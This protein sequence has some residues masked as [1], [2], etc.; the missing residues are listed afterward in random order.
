V[1]LLRELGVRFDLTVEPGAPANPLA[2]GE[3]ST[4]SMPDFA[5]APREPYRPST[6]D[7][8]VPDHG[9]ASD[10][11]LIPQSSADPSPALPIKRRI[12][13]RVRYPFRPTHRPLTLYRAW[14]SPQAF[15]DMVE[16]HVDSLERPYLAFA[17]RSGEPVSDN[18]RR[19]RAVLEHLLEHPLAGRLRFTNPADGLV[20]PV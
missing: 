3:R 18:V 11:L 16:H 8:L 2:P 6:S 14:T 4:G 20:E 5:H 17:L 12:G 1:R 19:A 9:A 7:Y 10:L 13:R 15:W